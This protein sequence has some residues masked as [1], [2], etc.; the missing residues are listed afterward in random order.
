M[1]N[2]QRRMIS[3]AMDSPEKLTDWEVEFIDS[4]ADKDDGYKLSPKQREILYRISK[5]VSF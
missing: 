3:E 4:L 2:V 1:D 5:T